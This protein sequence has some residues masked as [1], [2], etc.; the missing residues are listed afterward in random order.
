MSAWQ[1]L[2]EEDKARIIEAT[3]NEDTGKDGKDKEGFLTEINIYANDRPGLLN[4]ITRTFS[5]MDVSLLKV[6]TMVS[7]H[8]IATITLAFAIVSKNQ[9]RDIVTKLQAIRDVQAVKRTSG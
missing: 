7:K 5:E 3:W 4:E 6:N 9:L 1:N 2:S 8:K